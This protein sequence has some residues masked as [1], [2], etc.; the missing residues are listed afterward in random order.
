MDFKHVG[1]PP[2]EN[3]T[4]APLLFSKLALIYD[5]WKSQKVLLRLAGTSIII[6]CPIEK[7]E[8]FVGTVSVRTAREEEAR[9]ETSE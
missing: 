3:L 7:F 4:S 9:G 5:D 1:N 6:S 8:P 2:A